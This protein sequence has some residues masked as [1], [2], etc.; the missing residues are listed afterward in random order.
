MAGGHLLKLSER[1]VLMMVVHVLAAE[2]DKQSTDWF[3]Q[4]HLQ[5]ILKLLTGFLD[6]VKA[7]NEGAPAKK[8]RRLKGVAFGSSETSHTAPARVKVDNRLRKLTGSSVKLAY[9]FRPRFSPQVCF[10]LLQDKKGGANISF[11]I[12]DRKLVVYAYHLNAEPLHATQ[13]SHGNSLSSERCPYFE[14]RFQA[15]SGRD[16]QM[17]DSLMNMRKDVLKNIPCEIHPEE[18]APEVILENPSTCKTEI[19]TEVG[20]L[21]EASTTS[22]FSMNLPLRDRLSRKNRLKLRKRQLEDLLTTSDDESERENPCALSPVLQHRKSIV[23]DW[24]NQSSDNQ[25]TD[26]AL[27]ISENEII[28]SDDDDNMEMINDVCY[29]KI[30]PS[31]G[32]P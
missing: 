6:E 26:E 28:I 13:I 11:D 30:E 19:K 22:N 1:V 23:I 4:N 2:H 16:E 25:A 7:T 20:N 31:A 21:D 18:S 32:Y 17:K 14:K 12:L 15:S 5:E 3:T 27:P 24:V 10:P 8:R 9:R 29:L